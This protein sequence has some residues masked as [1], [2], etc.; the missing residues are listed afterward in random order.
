MKKITIEFAANKEDGYGQ[1]IKD[2]MLCLNA[3]E[4]Q[5]V[6][7]DFTEWLRSEMKYRDMHYYEPVREKIWE[8]INE[9]GIVLE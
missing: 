8:L 3:R 2:A 7:W 9:A 5:R 1:H 6:L 4:Y